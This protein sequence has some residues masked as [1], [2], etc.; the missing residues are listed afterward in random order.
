MVTSKLNTCNIFKVE[1]ALK[2]MHFPKTSIFQPGVLDR[3]SK[4]RFG[5]KLAS[6]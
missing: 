5:E 2:E 4:K 3:G 1:D 6:K